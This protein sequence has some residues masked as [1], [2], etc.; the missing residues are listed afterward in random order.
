[1][2][3]QYLINTDDN[4]QKTYD[5]TYVSLTVAGNSGQTHAVT[6]ENASDCRAWMNS[7]VYS[8]WKMITNNQMPDGSAFAYYNGNISASGDTVYISVNNNGPFSATINLKIR[9][10]YND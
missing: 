5:D 10:Y 9:V 8:G 1:M 4:I 3:S 7:S 6:A 2:T